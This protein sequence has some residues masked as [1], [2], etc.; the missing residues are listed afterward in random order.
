[1]IP[2]RFAASG[3]E[4]DCL[5]HCTGSECPNGCYLDLYGRAC[6]AGPAQGGRPVTDGWEPAPGA[7]HGGAAA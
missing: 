7:R 2:A 4:S 5:M 6:A 3:T 1:M